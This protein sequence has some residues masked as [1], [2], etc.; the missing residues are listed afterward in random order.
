M[1]TTIGRT[2]CW[3]RRVTPSDYAQDAPYGEALGADTQS[4]V[5]KELVRKSEKLAILVLFQIRF[6][7]MSSKREKA[8]EKRKQ[9]T[10]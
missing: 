2:S 1:R 7:P 10:R 5:F 8:Y 9:E 4:V 6:S 3:N